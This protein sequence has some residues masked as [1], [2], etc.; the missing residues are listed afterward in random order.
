MLLYYR[1][2]SKTYQIRQNKDLLTILK[3][4]IIRMCQNPTLQFSELNENYLAL[5]NLQGFHRKNQ[6]SVT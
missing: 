6:P 4:L 3:H 1:S 5:E 2:L